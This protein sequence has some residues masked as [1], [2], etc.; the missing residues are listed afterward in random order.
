MD[1]KELV[2]GKP[3]SGIPNNIQQQIDEILKAQKWL[4]DK[5]ADQSGKT[6]LST[7]TISKLFLC[8]MYLYRPGMISF[9]CTNKFQ[10]SRDLYVHV[11]ISVG[12]Y[13]EHLNEIGKF[14]VTNMVKAAWEEMEKYSRGSKVVLGAG[15]PVTKIDLKEDT[16]EGCGFII[17]LRYRSYNDR[18][19]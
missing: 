14:I 15:C 7:L 17:T 18:T 5:F 13:P 6:R 19:V 4:E 1:N 9:I 3:L 12:T 10:R 2:S 11:P 16:K 8:G